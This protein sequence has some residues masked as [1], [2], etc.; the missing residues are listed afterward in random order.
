MNAPRT[1]PGAPPAWHRPQRPG[2]V[3]IG[4]MLS[5]PREGVRP[6]LLTPLGP[7]HDVRVLIRPHPLPQ[8]CLEEPGSGRPGPRGRSTDAEAR[9]SA[10]IDPLWRLTRQQG[11]QPRS[12][13]GW[14]LGGS[15][16]F[17]PPSGPRLTSSPRILPF[18]ATW[19]NKPANQRTLTPVTCGPRSCPGPAEHQACSWKAPNHK[20]NYLARVAGLAVELR[21]AA[22]LG[23]S[24]LGLGLYCCRHE[25]LCAGFLQREDR[26]AQPG[27]TRRARP[28]SPWKLGDAVEDPCALPG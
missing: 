10:P 22:C 18:V 25:K 9:G 21:R 20:R 1:V 24:K 6:A 7:D 8:P 5:T 19:S 17:L 11:R 3:G 4:S 12:G 26:R 27:Y 15:S 16:S 23:T 13:S 14:S 2:R 28:I